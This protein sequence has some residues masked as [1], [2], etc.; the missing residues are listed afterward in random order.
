MK[1]IDNKKKKKQIEK[2]TFRFEW[3]LENKTKWV[4]GKSSM[5]VHCMSC[6]WV[7]YFRTLSQPQENSLSLFISHVQAGVS[8]KMPLV[9][10]GGVW[11]LLCT[12]LQCVRK[13]KVLIFIVLEVAVVIIIVVV[14]I[15]SSSSSSSSA[16][17]QP[18]CDNLQYKFCMLSFLHSLT[19]KLQRLKIRDWIGL[20]S[21]IPFHFYIYI[22]IHTHTSI[23]KYR[24]QHLH[25]KCLVISW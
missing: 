19:F 5:L 6:K 2:R 14:G 4:G 10:A 9:F 1:T 13:K 24:S 15:S 21:T 17:D 8:R 25:Y 11:L 12:R 3:L 20:S 22:H 18:N 23:Y 16:L 7:S